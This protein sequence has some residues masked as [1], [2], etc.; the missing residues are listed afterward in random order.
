MLVSGWARISCQNNP[1]S[2]ITWHN[3]TLSFSFTTR[4]LRDDPWPRY[5]DQLEQLDIKYIADY[6]IALTTHVMAK[7]RN[8]SKGLQALINGKYIIIESFISALVEAARQGSGG[9]AEPSPLERDFD[10]AW[11]NAL[12]HLPP[13]GEEPS[14]RPIS[15]Y[16]PDERRLDVFDG[17]TFIFYETKQYE[18]LFAPITNGK[19]KALL[20][21]VVAGETQIDDFVRYVKEVAGEKGLGEFEDGSEGKGVVVVRYAPSKG[22]GDGVVFQLSGFS[23][24]PPGPATHQPARTFSTPSWQSSPP[25]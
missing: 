23:L 14:D 6:D 16:A 20:R 9:D 12:E 1:N 13:R 15:T 19:G 18:N 22:E 25:C 4:E 7:K 5:R 21:E 10:G 8:T 2:R 24:A 17:Y 3:V 11:P